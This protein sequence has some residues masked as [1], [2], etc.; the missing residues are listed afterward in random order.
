MKRYAKRVMDTDI[1]GIRRMFEAAGTD[2]INLGLG[3]PDFDTPQ[4]IKNAAIEA[5]RDGHTGYTHGLGIPELRDAV[6]KKLRED[7]GI[8]AKADEV[9]ITSGASEALCLAMLA[10]L[11]EG[12]E[13]LVPD[14]G[15]VSYRALATFAGAVPVGVPLRELKMDAS[16][17]EEH[18]TERTRM[19]V[20]NSPSNPTGRV[21]KRGE[22]KALCEV[23]EEHDITILSDEV[24]EHFLY[25]GEHI[26]PATLY[27][28]VITVNATSKT[29]A[30]TGWRIGYAHAPSETIEQMLKLHQY[31]QA[32][33]PSISQWAA[34]AALTGPQECVER[35]RAEYARRREVVLEALKRMGLRCLPPEGAF[36]AFPDMTSLGMDGNE[37]AAKLLDAKVITVPGSAFGKYGTPYLRISYAT[38][39]DRLE[40]G[41]HIMEN[42]LAT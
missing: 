20:L 27:D 19:L 31:M 41:L 15:F 6:A 33:A 40:R 39:I 38:S 25:E 3:Q 13:V 35:M 2:A 14:P 24:Y 37:A 10:L 22:V 30:M 23:A 16:V 12:D 21:L 1:S 9:I 32:C 29:Y 11:E 26:S 28:N 36:Y 5:L 4:H 34:L 18:I 17:V 8:A 42:V 7:N